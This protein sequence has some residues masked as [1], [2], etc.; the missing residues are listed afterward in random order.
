[1]IGLL[2]LV[3]SGCGDMSKVA[4]DSRYD[5]LDSQSNA[6]SFRSYR[7]VIIDQCQY[8]DYD[9]GLAH[10]GNCTNEFHFKQHNLEKK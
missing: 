3:C 7:I 9:R 2:G 8:L 10:K 5:V 4:R 6:Y 1:M